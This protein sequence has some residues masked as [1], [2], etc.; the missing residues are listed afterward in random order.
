M[1]E[2]AADALHDSLRGKRGAD[3]ELLRV[4]V[5]LSEARRESE[6]GGCQRLEQGAVE[7]RKHVVPVPRSSLIRIGVIDPISFL[8]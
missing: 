4:E 7:R 8:C 1:V 2:R 5:W 3:P 6:V